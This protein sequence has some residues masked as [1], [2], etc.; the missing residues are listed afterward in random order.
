M[1]ESAIDVNGGVENSSVRIGESMSVVGLWKQ[2]GSSLTLT[3]LFSLSV[4]IH[5]V[6]QNY[7]TENESWTALESST[8]LLIGVL[9]PFPPFSYQSR[10]VSSPTR[11]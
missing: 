5:Y 8:L 4:T 3:V 1:G 2:Y 7:T 11:K 9:S 6:T 10:L